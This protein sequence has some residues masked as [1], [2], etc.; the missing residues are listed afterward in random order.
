VCASIVVKGVGF[1]GYFRGSPP[2]SYTLNST[3]NL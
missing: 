1:M 3:L 2:K